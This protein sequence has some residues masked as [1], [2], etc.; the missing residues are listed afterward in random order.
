MKARAAQPNLTADLLRELIGEIRALRSEL[1]MNRGTS[2]EKPRELLREIFE[3]IGEE[4]F[5]AAGLIDHAYVREKMDHDPRINDAIRR[6]LGT[7][8]ARKLGTYFANN[9]GE[10]FGGYFI[11]RAGATRIGVVWKIAP[12]SSRVS[13]SVGTRNSSKE[14]Q[15]Y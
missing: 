3:L 8:S 1:G 5:S 7:L 14:S 15:R 11:R 10:S 9:E 13:E 6:T 4:T 2:D 12:P